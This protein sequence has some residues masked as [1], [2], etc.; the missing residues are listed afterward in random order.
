MPEE[1]ADEAV[2]KPRPRGRA[3]APVLLL[4]LG[5]SLGLSSCGQSSTPANVAGGGGAVIKV[6]SNRADLVSG[7]DAL[8]EVDP[9]AGASASALRVSLNG[10][11]VTQAFGTGPSGQFMGLVTGL[12]DGN[13]TLIAGGASVTI[14]NHPQGGPVFAG[15]QLQPWT[16]EQGAADSQCNKA[17]AYSYVYMSTDPTK[18]GFQAY[19]PSSPPGDVATTTTDQG[20]SVPFIVR[21]ETGY[22]DRDQYAVAALYQPGKP[23]SALD[24]Q[25]QFNHKLLITHGVSCNVDYGVGTAPSV[26][27]YQPANLTGIAGGPTLPVPSALFA[28]SAQYALGKGFVV[29]STALDY[30]GHDCN[31]VVQAESLMMAKEHLIDEYGTLRYTIGT[32]CSGGSLAQQQVANAYPGVYQGVLPTCSFPDTWSSATQ[33]GDYHLLNAYFGPVQSGVDGGTAGVVWTPVQA[34]Q[35]E[36]NLLPVDSIV[37]DS[38]FFD[39]IVPTHA[40][41]YITDAQRYDPVNNI[42]GVRCSIADMAINVF[43]PRPPAVWNANEKKLGH[44]FAGLPIDN[45]GVQYGLATLQEGLITPAQFIDLNQKIGGLSID[46]QP[47]TSRVT[48]DEPALANAYRSGMINEANNYNSTAIIDCRGPDP[49]LAHD[50]YRAFAVR[51]R[52]LREHGSYANQ[53][54]WEGP[55]PIVGDVDC[56]QNSLIAMDSWLA[57]VEQDSSSAQ[58]S[59]KIVKDKPS[60]LSDE[61]WDGAG[62]KLTDELCPDVVVPSFPLILNIGV[63]PVYATPRMV[64]GNAITTDANKCQLKPLDQSDNYGPLGLSSA[65]WTQMQQIFPTGVCDYGHPGVDQQPTIPWQTY[66]DGQGK[67]IYG[68]QALPAPP[69]NSGEGWASP[70]FDPFNAS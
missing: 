25:Q 12:V 39:A 34:A 54:I 28:D 55:A 13:N 31:I 9:P 41:G 43:A 52:L 35:V 4:A 47:T 20:V 44:G 26:V 15:P 57:A 1:K 58:L 60:S 10:Q 50:A 65:Q 17:P 66:E 30:S 23:W 51:A 7:G 70:A 2:E 42:S 19:D 69:V 61:C 3:L 36:G 6:L 16:C 8:V 29:M 18:S 32:G 40:C 67:V 62:T 56:N 68:G 27:S 46:I 53:L 21:I 38:G 45:V 48:A 63:V 24:P 37:S 14:V 5:L 49:G 64:A 59:Q 11:D 33:V 22:Q